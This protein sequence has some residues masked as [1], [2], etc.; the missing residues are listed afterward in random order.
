MFELVREETFC[1]SAPGEPDVNIRSGALRQW[2]L[3]NAMDKLGD[4]QFPADETLDSMI[5]RHG[6]EADRL[7]SMTSE[8]AEDPV[9]V[10]DWEDGT[11]V[12]VDGA[13]RRAFWAQRGRHELKGWMVPRAL[14]EQFVYDP[15]APNV[16]Y[17]ADD[18]SLLPQRRKK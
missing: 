7:A 14:W 9:V 13:H 1:Y 18:G 17:Q 8:E 15:S 10:A 2:L 11:H 4:I 6:L 16:L 5:A 3:A 12:L